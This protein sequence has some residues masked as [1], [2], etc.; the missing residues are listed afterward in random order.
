M[1]SFISLS[2][3]SFPTSSS[4]PHSLSNHDMEGSNSV[5]PSFTGEGLSIEEKQAQS[6]VRTL[7]NW[8][9]DKTVIHSGK[10][11]HFVPHNGVYVYV[12]YDDNNKVMVALNKNEKPVTLD[13]IRYAE[14]LDGHKQ[15]FDV[16]TGARHD[17]SGPIEVPARGILL[18]ELK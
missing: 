14:Q 5:C 18:L 6:F 1:V 2:F 8:R 4:T 7:V 10:L 9:K 15:A 13:K 16:L 17:L 12:R 3:D 11:M